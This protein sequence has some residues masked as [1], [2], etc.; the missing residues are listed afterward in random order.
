[1][2]E[3]EQTS[4]V[5]QA[6]TPGSITIPTIVEP[7]RPPWVLYLATAALLVVAFVV[8]FG[9]VSN[10]VDRN[11]RLNAMVSK[12]ADVIAANDIQISD[13]IDDL[14]ASNENAQRLYD[15]LLAEGVQPDGVPPDVLTPDAGPRGPAGEIGPA[16]RPPT[17]AEVQAAVERFCA[18]VG[19]C[20]G[21]DGVD[22]APGP[23]GANGVDGASGTD[24]APGPAGPQGEQGPAGPQGPP[25]PACPEGY[26]IQITWV[27]ISDEEFGVYTPQPVPLCRPTAPVTEGTQ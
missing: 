10:L 2:T 6:V 12:Q 5:I 1:M 27:A 16:G 22:G 9:W 13:L 17:D 7:R 23:A 11:E 25:G 8:M 14:I 15:Q 24:G 19:G 3:D 4:E 20:Q 21:R 26:T 18:A